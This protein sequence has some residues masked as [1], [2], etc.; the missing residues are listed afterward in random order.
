MKQALLDPNTKDA[1]KVSVATESNAGN[2]TSLPSA[3]RGKRKRISTGTRLAQLAVF[4]RQLFVLTSC[5]TPLVEAMN[6][7]QRQT[8]NDTWRQVLAEVTE[9]VERGTSLSAAM[10]PHPDCFDSVTCTL[11]AAGEAA[12]NLEV[13]LDRLASVTQQRMTMRRSIMGSLTYPILL[14]SVASIAMVILLLFV[15]P[16]F[17]TMFES[18]NAPIPPS[19]QAIIGLS[20]FLRAYWWGAIPAAIGVVTGI[21]VLLRRP[22]GQRFIDRTQMR[23]PKISGIARSFV[24]ARIVRL[25]GVLI[26]ARVPLIDALVLTRT[27]MKNSLYVKMLQDAEDQVTQ[28]EPLSRAFNDPMLIS[29]SVYEALRSGEQGGQLGTLLLNMSDFLDEDNKTTAR[30][31]ATI[32]EPLI[33]ILLGLM[34]GFVAVSMFLPLFDLTAMAKGS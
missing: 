15:I 8:S 12:G 30:S 5:G 13:M 4:S 21:V 31:L 7:L 34:I 17:S 28:G 24:T 18:L 1:E 25:L 32:L 16:R 3:P 2:D 19:T 26:D 9:E 6:A 20:T 27:A 14:L 29:P 33:L 22:A 10:A 23:T 11:I